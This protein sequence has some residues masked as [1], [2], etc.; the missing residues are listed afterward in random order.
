M[1]LHSHPSFNSFLHSIK[2]KKIALLTHSGADVDALA[3][4]SSL[5]F[6]LKPEFKTKI[7]IPDHISLNAKIL[8]GKTQTPY[9][10]NANSLSEFKALIIVDLNSIEMLGSM[11]KKVLSF[12]GPILLIDHH[13]KTS[14]LPK[15]KNFHSI[16]DPK[17]VSSTEIVFYLLKESKI[18]L[19]PKTASLLAAGIITD[20]AGF[21]VADSDTFSSMAELMKQ[22]KKSFSEITELFES[23]PEPSQ[24]IA[25][26]KA[27][28]RARIYRTGEFIIV[29]AEIGAFEADAASILTRLGADLA[30]A[31]KAEKGLIRL[32]ARANNFFILKTRID[33]AKDILSKLDKKFEGNSGGHSGAAGFNGKGESIEKVFSECLALLKEFLKLKSLNAETKEYT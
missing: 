11:K 16:I 27:A 21:H 4:A 1:Q 31:G 8:A 13:T 32:S 33:L 10:I 26:L 14:H 12:K 6:A 17:K 25:K 20:S 7:I 28:K 24:K 5:Y 3:S 30:F 29:T 2:G 15:T 19:N 18:K 23:K 9:T 22:S